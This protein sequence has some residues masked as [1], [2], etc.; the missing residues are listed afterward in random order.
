[1][2]ISGLPT[3]VLQRIAPDVERLAGREIAPESDAPLT[4]D[5]LALR[6]IRREVMSHNPAGTAADSVHLSS[7][8][9]DSRQQRIADGQ[10]LTGAF[11]FNNNVGNALSGQQEMR[12]LSHN[13]NLDMVAQL[14]DAINA[15]RANNPQQPNNGSGFNVTV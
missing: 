3:S 4:E 15:L 5:Q 6:R 2:N 12:N 13:A 8:L 1:M 10:S 11:G 14:M 9:S 7:M